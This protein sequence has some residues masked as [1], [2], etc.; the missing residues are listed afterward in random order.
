MSDLNMQVINICHEQGCSL[1][2]GGWGRVVRLPRA[3]R[4]RRRKIRGQNEYFKCKNFI[5]SP[6][7]ILGYSGTYTEI[8]RVTVIFLKVHNFC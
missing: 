2:G 4:S 6:H 5:S 3:S 8:Q 7:R 1:G